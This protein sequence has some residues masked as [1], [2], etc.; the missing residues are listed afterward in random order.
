VARV[1]S[2][3]VDPMECPYAPHIAPNHIESE[4][5]R[6]LPHSTV[7]DDGVTSPKHRFRRGQVLYSKLRPYLAKVVVADFDGVCSADMYPIDTVLDPHFLKWW[8]LTREFTRRAAGEQARTVLPKINVRALSKLPVPLPPPSEQRRIVEILEDHLSRLDAA[9][10]LTKQAQR[11]LSRLRDA[12]AQAA[13]TEARHSSVDASLGDLEQSGRKI[14]YGVLVPGPHVEDGVSLIRIGDLRGGRIDTSQM[15]H[16]APEIAG[17]FKRTFVRGG[18]VLLSLVGTIGRT[19]VVPPSLA[20]ANVARA[21]CVLPLV[22]AVQPEF[23][24][25]IL[26]APEIRRSLNRQAHEVARKTLNLEDVK[27][28]VIPLPDLSVQGK[29]L[30]DFCV[31]IDRIERLE[32]AVGDAQDRN[33]ALRQSLLAAAFA[34]RLTGDRVDDEVLQEFAGV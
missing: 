29:I 9:T 12:A 1:A 7:R 18:E 10:V 8:M 11:S 14:A 24:S 30:D 26:S 25:T 32:S 3:L 21:I 23:V 28:L 4:T 33:R 22:D 6:L 5:G 17:R 19:A 31:T 20:G 13:L 34:G 15:K 16:I 2:D 27:R